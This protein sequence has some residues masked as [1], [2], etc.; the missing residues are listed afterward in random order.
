MSKAK[1][2]KELLTAAEW[3]L[4][5]VGWTKGYMALNKDNGV[6]IEDDYSN[7]GSVCL[8]G[9]FS[10][11]DI[12]HPELFSKAVAHFK[13]V[14]NIYSISYFNDD[15]TRTKEQVLAAVRKAIKAA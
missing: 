15:K 8:L 3:V 4:K 12:S 14:N 7:L 5:N 10:V 1:S 13:Q 9:A 2:V 6:F 11:V